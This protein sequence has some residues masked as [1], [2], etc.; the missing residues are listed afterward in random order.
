MI[1][2]HF[3]CVTCGMQFAPAEKP[4]AACPICQDARQFVSPAGQRWAR[5]ADLRGNFRN[6]IR[7]VDEQLHSIVTRP[8]FAIG[9]RAYLIQTT[10]GNILWD[11]VAYIDA[12]TISAIW[13]LGGIAAI[14]ISHPHY[15][16]TMAEWS[17][18]FGGI[19]ILIHADDKEWVQRPADSLQ[20]WSGEFLQLHDGITL[21]RCGGHFAGASVLHWPGAC[22]GK[23]A[24][25]TGD[26]IQVCPDQRSVSFMYSYPNFIPL[27]A[28][29][30]RKIVGAIESYPV[31][32]IYGAFGN[33]IE[34]RGSDCIR[35]SAERYIQAIS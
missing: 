31:E 22:D 12:D 29:S 21:I 19:P 20:L 11:C 15:Y 7:Q 30:I 14:A 2:Q 27:N 3:I 33:V 32:R 16:T 6:E 18:L 28:A 13:A 23:G 4:P 25:L 5:L 8:Q 10:G 1:S 35:K 9:Q 34:A 24:L 26:T 17:A